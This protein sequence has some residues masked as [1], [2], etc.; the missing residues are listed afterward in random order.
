MKSIIFDNKTIND[1]GEL[2]LQIISKCLSTNR[3]FN[4]RCVD[5][6]ISNISNL[7]WQKKF[8]CRNFIFLF[9][10][11]IYEKIGDLKFMQMCQ[12]LDLL[13]HFN[14]PKITP[15]H[16]ILKKLEDKVAFFEERFYKENFD[17][18]NLKFN[19]ETFMVIRILR[20]LVAH[21]GLID[22][23]IAKNII[24]DD[25]K[26]LLESFLKENKNINER[27]LACSFNYLIE[28]IFFR[29]MGLGD[30]ELLANGNPPQYLSIFIKKVK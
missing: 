1:D 16:L 9:K 26:K 24:I 15:D 6:I 14:N 7:K 30:D 25:Q 22:M 18:K 4:D 27:I 3:T 12:I 21:S 20:N 5:K 2:M 11:A 13:Y 29:S 23:N 28:D 8:Y 17:R 19:K 10:N